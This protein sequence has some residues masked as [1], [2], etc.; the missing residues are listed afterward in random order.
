MSPTSYQLL[1]SAIFYFC[2]AGDRT[3][4]GTVSLPGDFKSPVSTNSTTPAACRQWLGYHRHTTFVKHNLKK[5]KN[6]FRQA[7]TQ[8][9]GSADGRKRTR[10]S[11]RF[12][13][14]R[15]PIQ[16]L[17]AGDTK[18]VF[19]RRTAAKSGTHCRITACS[20]LEHTLQ[21]LK[22]GGGGYEAAAGRKTHEKGQGALP[23]YSGKNRSY[24][25]LDRPAPG[26][27]GDSGAGRG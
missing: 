7:V 22:K 9:A 25:K 2:G 17:L 14:P 6:F 4:T 1:Y 5:S 12:F 20:P 18:N 27:P 21:S 23:V 10:Q 24:G 15:R 3:R 8:S 26:S 13:R 11:P 16:D 19:N